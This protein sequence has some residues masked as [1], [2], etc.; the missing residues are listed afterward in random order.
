MMTGDAMG[1]AAGASLFIPGAEPA[2]P[3]LAIGG[4]GIFAVGG[5][6]Y[7]MDNYPPPFG[8]GPVSGLA[9]LGYGTYKSTKVGGKNGN[10]P[11]FGIG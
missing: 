5:Y 8:G 6:G 7:L 10:T 4:F 2:A 11:G 1:L 3:F 9:A